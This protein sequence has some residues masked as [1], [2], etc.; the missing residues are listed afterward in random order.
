MPCV[1][2]AIADDEPRAGVN[3]ARKTSQPWL[4]DTSLQQPTLPVR[5]FATTI[6]RVLVANRGE[7]ACRIMRTLR[8]LGVESVA[9]YGDEDR[10]ALH[11]KNADLAMDL[12]K[13]FRY[14]QM[15][16]IVNAALR[17]NAKA[18][19]P[20][21]GF[22]SENHKFAH[23]CQSQGI[24]FIGPPPSAILSMGDKSKAKEI[25]TSAEVPVV[26]GYHGKEQDATFLQA[27]ADRIGY[28]VLIKATQGGGGKG[29][30]IVERQDDFPAKLEE[31]RREV[32]LSVEDTTVLVE[33]Y[34]A[35]ARHVEVQVVADKHHNV[36]H[37]FERDCSVQRRHQKIIEEAPAPLLSETFR[38]SI[39]Q[40]AVSAAKAVGYESAGT[41]EFIVDTGSK[42]F[43]F[44]E[45]NTRLQVEHPITELVTGVDIV[46]W[47]LLVARGLALPLR[48]DQI[49]S[50]G[51]AFE[52]RVCA[53]NVSLGFLPS[54]GIIQMCQ[55]PPTSS[56]VRVDSGVEEGGHVSGVF[57]PMIAKVA[58]WDVDRQAA[59]NKL[60][61]S[62]QDYKIA[63]VSTNLAFLQRL[64]KHPA[65][66]S[67]DVDTHFLQRYPDVLQDTGNALD[68]R[69]SR[70]L[71]RGKSPGS[72]KDMQD[73]AVESHD[74]T[75]AL[76]A[77]VTAAAMCIIE[78][79]D[80]EQHLHRVHPIWSNG[81][82][83]RVNHPHSQSVQL[84]K[85]SPDGTLQDINVLV[86]YLKDG[87]L[88]VK[89][90]NKPAVHLQ[91]RS[92]DEKGNFLI[93]L[94]DCSFRA[95]FVQYVKGGN[96]HLEI[97]SGGS[98]AHFT[99]QGP[100]EYLDASIFLEKQGD[101]GGPTQLQARV[102]SGSKGVV[103]SPMAGRVVKVS[104]HSGQIVEKGMNVIVLEAMKME[105]TVKAPLSGVV[106][107][108]SVS[109]GE[110]VQDG[111][112]LFTIKEAS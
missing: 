11:V 102:S 22:L 7:I 25:M 17:A 1:A 44:M 106:D 54:P 24:E 69:L 3:A 84:S 2:Q 104:A 73:A 62:L 96:L 88:I 79:H 63:G 13:S 80:T 37:L 81:M 16:A 95:T 48:Q 68:K 108:L 51:H 31:A 57:D 9:V 91:V 71:S 43:Y 70:L 14:L 98:S 89:V 5:A 55:Q 100:T 83:F 10:N 82:G 109:V 8:R 53:E 47:Q 15:D 19:H 56:T 74:S 46:E 107:G 20:G 26:P 32:A 29:M 99:V 64:A 27:E 97:F 38:K 76:V 90:D 103:V 30:R 50:K 72:G 67:A 21:Y 28:P 93:I 58:V 105:H 18:I 6:D 94:D 42:D 66:V 33:K 75:G 77:A 101:G 40:A 4:S 41:V 85:P 59:L 110:Q 92:L 87:T 65:F 112:V 61:R 23:M 60:H 49:Q 34:I 52:A 111:T 86:T 35:K 36:L 39:C 78:R 12:G 45:M